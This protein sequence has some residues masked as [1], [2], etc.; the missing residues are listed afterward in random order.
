ML[1]RSKFSHS[2]VLFIMGILHT[3]S[4]PPFLGRS[5]HQLK[6]APE[7]RTGSEFIAVFSDKFLTYWIIFDIMLLEI[8]CYLIRRFVTFS[9]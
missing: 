3:G 4:P 8:K 5:P 2:Y 1:S 9:F 6:S 7:S